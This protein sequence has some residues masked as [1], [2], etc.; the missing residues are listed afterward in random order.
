MTA[1]VARPLSEFPSERKHSATARHQRKN[2]A[3]R[4]ELILQ[5]VPAKHGKSE[6]VKKVNM[7]IRMSRQQV[8]QR[9]L[10]HADSMP[11][12]RM[13][14]LQCSPWHCSPTILSC[15]LVMHVM[16]CVQIYCDSAGIQFNY[17][18]ITCSCCGAITAANYQPFNSP[19]SCMHTRKTDFDLPSPFLRFVASWFS[20]DVP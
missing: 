5:Y 3:A 18:D 13:T 12:M 16:L 6:T 10:R 17:V 1:T 4:V 9:A 2:F 15:A 8:A 7:L 20:A 11:G 19:A 14:M